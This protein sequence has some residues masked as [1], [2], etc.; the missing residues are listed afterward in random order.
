MNFKRFM[1]ETPVFDDDSKVLGNKENTHLSHASDLKTVERI[2]KGKLISSQNIGEYL[3]EVYEKTNWVFALLTKNNELIGTVDA[4]TGKYKY[5]KV[6]SSFVYSEHQGKGLGKQMYENIIE[7]YNGLISDVKLTG[8]DG[9]GSVDVWIS[10]S[11]KYHPF[12]VYEKSGQITYKDIKSPFT[13]DMM[14]NLFQMFG[15]KR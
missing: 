6:M 13:R 1:T 9:A 7:H 15:V 3:I 8:K 4:Y 5:P 2:R 12:I 11:K 14:G 10:L